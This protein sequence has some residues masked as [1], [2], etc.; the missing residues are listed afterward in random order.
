MSGPPPP[1]LVDAHHHVWDLSHRPQPWLEEAGLAPIRRSFSADDL[2][3]QATRPIAGRSLTTTVVVQCTAS[4]PETQDLLA[5]A[6]EHP[7]IGAVVGWADLTTLSIGDI[8]DALLAGP[9]GAYLRSLRH[10]VQAETDPGWLQRPDVTRG[11]RAVE[12]RGLAYD[13]LV[14]AHQLPSAVRLAER[15]PELRLVLD[16]AGKPPLAEGDLADWEKHLRRLAAHPLV[17]CKVSGLATEADH[18]TWSSRDIRPV[19][20]TLLSAFGPER[21]MFGSDW[22]LCLLTGGWNRWAGAVAELLAGFSA[23]ES[24]SVLSGSATAFY[25]I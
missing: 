25:R 24:E 19:W 14:R 8:L 7:L 17:M 1:A 18:T 3:V 13:I 22:P 6:D 11:L 12:Q 15:H 2:R 4:V 5:L 23:A 21:L 9:G 16:H 10:L 20:D